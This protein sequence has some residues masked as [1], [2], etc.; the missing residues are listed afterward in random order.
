MQPNIKIPELNEMI[1]SY[2]IRKKIQYA[3]YFSEMNDG[4]NGMKAE[5]TTDG[6]H[7][8]AKGY[9]VMESILQPL[10]KKVLKSK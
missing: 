7:C 6:V 10:I 9:D 2:C 1:K 5:L 3:D 4:N 8:T